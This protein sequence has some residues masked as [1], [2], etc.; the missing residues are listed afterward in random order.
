MI[1]ID[2]KVKGFF[3]STIDDLDLDE[4]HVTFSLSKT[5]CVLLNEPL[6]F[7]RKL[8]YRNNEKI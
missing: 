2:K 7:W 8:F 5:S 4:R 6:K 3:A 1:Q